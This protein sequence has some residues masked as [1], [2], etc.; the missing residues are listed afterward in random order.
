MANGTYLPILDAPGVFGTRGTL[1]YPTEEIEPSY[2]QAVFKLDVNANTVVAMMANKK[3]RRETNSTWKYAAQRLNRGFANC[4]VWNGSPLAQGAAT[5]LSVTA[6]TAIA[7]GA[8]VYAVVPAAFCLT[9]RKKNTV[10]LNKPFAP[11]SIVRAKVMDVVVNG[12]SS[13]IKLELLQATT[14]AAMGLATE[15]SIIGNVAQ[16]GDFIGEG[17][18]YS[19]T[20]FE[21]YHQ[22]LRNPI[23]LTR[24]A[25]LQKQ[26]F[27]DGTAMQLQPQQVLADHLRDMNRTTLFQNKY[28]QTVAGQPEYF[29]E[30]IFEAIT[31]PDPENP[32]VRG[33]NVRNFY[34][35]ECPTGR[36]DWAA[37]TNDSAYAGYSWD[38]AGFN[39][40]QDS[41]KQLF[42]YGP[43]ERTCLCGNEFLDGVQRAVWA[44][45]QMKLESGQT[46]FGMSISKWTTPYGVV[47][48]KTVDEFVTDPSLTHTGVFLVP[49]YITPVVLTDSHVTALVDDKRKDGTSFDG[50]LEEWLFD[51]SAEYDGREAM[52][53]LNGVGKDNVT[54]T[55]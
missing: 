32:T 18:A 23:K 11:E 13:Y 28:M 37:G 12:S 19:K 29:M 17:V 27:G 39:F 20:I 40:L 6:S 41:F 51:G 33:P 48:F 31:Y 47:Y 53:I 49:D 2:R 5:Y 21:Q 54:Y 50:S 8:T 25:I 43:R 1:T 38:F 44:N 24:N 30:G 55:P 34:T 4:I 10:R 26:R 16:E 45:G 52:M 9:I 3:P 46:D 36:S 35:G 14:Y 22:I 15:L 7:A 42:T